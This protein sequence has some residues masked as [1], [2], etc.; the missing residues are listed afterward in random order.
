[1]RRFSIVIIAAASTVAI[2]QIASA[3]DMPV[4][5]PV[6]TPVPSSNWTGF[7]VGGTVGYGWTD[8]TVTPSANDPGSAKLINGG[9]PGGQPLGPASF[10]NKGEF[11]GVEAGYNWQFS[12]S[13]LVGVEADI[14]ASNINGTG[15]SA[16]AAQGPPSTPFTQQL[17]AS[18]N[19]QWFGTV[20]VRLGWLATMT[21]SSTALADLLT[22]V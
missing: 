11:G 3:A 9:F 2:T 21:C 16:S 19:V 12:P 14:N 8:P 22:V 7:Y 1:M 5:A 13:W 6:V 10:E 15:I 18:Q 20:R 4:K 17:S